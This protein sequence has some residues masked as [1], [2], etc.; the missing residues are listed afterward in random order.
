[1]SENKNVDSDYYYNFLKKFNFKIP[2]DLN[3]IDRVKVK[4]MLLSHNLYLTSNN[5]KQKRFKLIT[6]DIKP[7]F[8]N[9]YVK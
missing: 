2:D 8:H 5:K 3:H 6:K 1:M 9:R 7:N 4:K